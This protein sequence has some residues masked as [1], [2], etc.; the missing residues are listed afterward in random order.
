MLHFGIQI[1]LYAS[2]LF[3]TQQQL[4]HLPVKISSLP[5]WK[6]LIAQGLLLC[7][8]LILSCLGSL[9]FGN[10]PYYS[11]NPCAFIR[12]AVCFCNERPALSEI[13]YFM[14]IFFFYSER[15]LLPEIY[16]FML[17]LFIQWKITAIRN[18]LFCVWFIYT[19]KDHHYSK[20]FMFG[21]FL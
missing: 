17:A 21:L 19:V 16:Y 20:Y 7:N 5:L 9:W 8:I 10:Y 1:S 3:G 2:Y 12:S 13:F 15:P 4:T 6:N 11:L 18:I 14:I